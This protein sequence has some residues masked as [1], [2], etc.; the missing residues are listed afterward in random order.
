MNA[1]I[2]KGKELPHHTVT[3]DTETTVL[4]TLS[5]YRKQLSHFKA[6]IGF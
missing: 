1:V 2:K 6:I 3:A 4:F 5:P